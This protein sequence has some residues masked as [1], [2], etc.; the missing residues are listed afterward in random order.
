MCRGTFVG[1]GVLLAFVMPGGVA[2]ALE[3]PT[4]SP[5]SVGVPVAVGGVVPVPLASVESS[6]PGGVFEVG[7]ATF[8]AEPMFVSVELFVGDGCDGDP[9]E[10]ASGIVEA[11]QAMLGQVAMPDGSVSAAAST[12][13]WGTEIRS[14]CTAL[15]AV[16]AVSTVTTQQDGSAVVSAVGTGDVVALLAGTSSPAVGSAT[17]VPPPLTTTSVVERSKTSVVPSPV[18]LDAAIGGGRPVEGDVLAESGWASAWLAW[19]AAAALVV[20]V[21]I[22]WWVSRSLKSRAASEVSSNEGES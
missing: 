21:V 18:P 2:G 5:V 1:A 10:V 13:G 4:T 15:V 8:G 11:G 9:F 17:T 20:G 7:A 12:S 14:D 3:V 22:N 16:E 19:L 6:V